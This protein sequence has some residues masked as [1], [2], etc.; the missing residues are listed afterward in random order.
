[1]TQTD[2][3]LAERLRELTLDRPDPRSLAS[4]VLAVAAQ[5]ERQQA[6]P[7]PL[8]VAAAMLVAIA[9]AWGVLYF[10]PITGAALADAS[11]GSATASD[12]LRAVGLGAGA[13][14]SAQNSTATA[15]GYRIQL[16]GA[17]TDSIRTV[18]LLKITPADAMSFVG[19]NLSDQFGSS[20]ELLEGVA[21]TNTGDEALVFGPPRGLA[22]RTGLRFSVDLRLV[23]TRAGG[24]VPGA[25][26]VSGT[27]L[28]DAG[29]LLDPP[30]PGG[31]GAGTVTFRQPRSAGGVLAVSADIAGLS[32]EQLGASV[33]SGGKAQ[34]ALQAV[35][36]DPTGTEL[37]MNIR[38]SGA[39]GVSRFD[40]VAFGIHPGTYRLRLTLASGGSLER[41][42][43]VR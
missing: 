34:L 28:P 24:T 14:V 4:R 27:V 9:G 40:A 36:V 30:A 41:I 5:P 3:R 13:T 26:K 17:S 32:T 1:M 29:T 33:P 12:V 19:V 11:G 22:A 35:L 23:S 25:W 10:S 15:S 7:R 38:V 21:T 42:L 6:I 43:V 16:V 8:L 2:D 18:V 39:D 37:P 31:L 20:Y